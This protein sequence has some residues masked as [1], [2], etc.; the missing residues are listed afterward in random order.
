LRE[1]FTH[2]RSG[3]SGFFDFPRKTRVAS[4]VLKDLQNL[5]VRAREIEF[6]DCHTKPK[7]KQIA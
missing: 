4:V 6:A 2:F 7:L 3:Y 1:K 5:T